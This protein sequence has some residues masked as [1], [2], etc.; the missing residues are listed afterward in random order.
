MNTPTTHWTVIVEEDPE[1]GDLMLPFPDDLLDQAGWKEG[2]TL[3]WT[4]NPDNTISI[5]KTSP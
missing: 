5:V 3:K 2:D 4:I 1:S